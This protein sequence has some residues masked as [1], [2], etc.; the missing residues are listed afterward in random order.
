MSDD[1]ENWEALQL[2]RAEAEDDDEYEHLLE[3]LLCL[4]VNHIAM[5][6]ALDKEKDEEDEHEETRLLFHEPPK[7]ASRQSIPLPEFSTWQY[8]IDSSDGT[9]E[10][11][12]T[13]VGLS[14]ISFLALVNE[15]EP[16]WKAN[17]QVAIRGEHAVGTPRPRWLL[18]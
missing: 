16:Y 6:L 17:A 4:A 12:F 7:Y 3:I 11:W 5:A 8:L 10:T 1:G 18:H 13:W 15:C 2:T 14:K 9:D